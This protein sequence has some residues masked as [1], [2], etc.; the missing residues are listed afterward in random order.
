MSQQ[1]HYDLP[2]FT[3]TPLTR[4]EIRLLLPTN[5]EDGLSWTMQVVLSYVWGPQDQTFPVI[6][7]GQIHHV[8]HNLHTALPYLANRHISFR[9]QK[10]A[11]DADEGDDLPTESIEADGVPRPIWID[12]QCINQGDEEEMLCQIRSMNLIYQRATMVWAWLDLPEDYDLLDDAIE[13][14]PKITQVARGFSL[15]VT[16]AQTVDLGPFFLR[17]IN[18]R[19]WRVLIHLVSNEWYRCVWILQEL[20]L[21]HEITFL[22]GKHATSFALLG[23]FAKRAW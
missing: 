19:V 1:E 16:L 21:A 15:N 3:Y 22:C 23:R 14:L 13:L 17:N 7:N 11:D 8:H 10:V 5:D 6:C 12:A 2:P 18:A 4:G 20:A 9:S